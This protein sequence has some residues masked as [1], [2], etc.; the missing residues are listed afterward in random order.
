MDRRNFLNKTALTTAAAMVGSSLLCFTAVIGQN[1][2]NYDE[3]KVPAYDLP[4]PLILFNGKKVKNVKTWS[5][6]RRPEVLKL[7]EEEVYGRIPGELNIVSY[8]VVEE[9]NTALNNIAIRKQVVLKFENGGK[10]LSA[11]LLIYL[12][13]NV[14]KV[15]MF[16]GYNFYG[17]HTIVNDDQVILTT[18]WIR[19][20]PEFGI[21]NN[22]STGESRGVRTNRWPVEKII[23]AG[24]GLATMYYGDID[25]DRN[26]F[27]DGIQW[28]KSKKCK[29]LV[30]QTQ[31]GSPQT[32]RR[33]GLWQDSW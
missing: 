7:F 28:E 6:K 10:D 26:D 8:Q 4:E 30:K 16:I 33:R 31:T 32:F 25:P 15:P 23:E 18:S 2:P 19:N 13:R 20:N 22:Q 17:N 29:N 14:D 24:Y 3:I 9:S 12:P 11:G 21:T 27:S 5:N 1:Q